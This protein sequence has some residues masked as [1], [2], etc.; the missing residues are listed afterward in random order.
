MTTQRCTKIHELLRVEEFN[1]LGAFVS[2][3]RCSD[4]FQIRDDTLHSRYYHLHHPS[5]DGPG[6]DFDLFIVD[7]LIERI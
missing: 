3:L 2:C 1:A 6:E 7:F 5:P 4:S